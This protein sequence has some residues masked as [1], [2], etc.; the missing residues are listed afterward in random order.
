MVTAAITIIWVMVSMPVNGQLMLEQ[1]FTTHAACEEARQR[2]NQGC[3]PVILLNGGEPITPSAADPPVPI[4][5]PPEPGGHG[6]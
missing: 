4:N 1:A 5:K 6:R 2:A 3:E